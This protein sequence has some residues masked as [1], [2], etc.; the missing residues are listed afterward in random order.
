MSDICNR[1]LNLL[2]RVIVVLVA[3]ASHFQPA[4]AVAISSVDIQKAISQ[5]KEELP[6]LTAA[7]ELCKDWGP[8]EANKRFDSPLDP[9][10]QA[11]WDLHQCCANLPN[12]S[13][14]AAGPVAALI[15]FDQLPS[16]TA[17]KG[18]A[19]FRE[20]T[21]IIA[22][23]LQEMVSS[24]TEDSIDKIR[25]GLRALPKNGDGWRDQCTIAAEKL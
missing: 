18:G 9:F 23:H 12:A 19:W 20:V 6:V 15:P 7:K 24:S 1:C 16:I 11:G 3:F 2:S 14:V 4:P 10:S 25:E 5:L 22:D 8:D 13:V 17:S 21:E